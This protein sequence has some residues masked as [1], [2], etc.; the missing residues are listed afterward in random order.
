MINASKGIARILKME[1]TAF[2]SLF[3]TCRLN[4]AIGDEGEIPIIMMRDERYGVAVADAFSR[5]SDGKKF[6]VC[7]VQGGVNAAGLEFA[8]AAIMQAFEDSSPVLCLTDGLPAFDME[9]SH[10]QA[11]RVFSHITRWVSS[12]PNAQRVPDYMARAFTFLKT[13]RPGPVLLQVPPNLGDY[14]EEQYPYEPVK[15]WK[16]QADP[17][18]VKSVVRSLL[19]AK[20]PL[21]YVGEGVFRA[22]ACAELR[23]FVEVSQIP[24]LTTLKGKS[25]FPENH[26][27]SVGVRGEPGEYYLDKCDLLLALGSSLSPNRF[28]H[29]IP[30]AWSKT[31]I[32]CTID[33]LDINKSYRVKHALIGDSKLVL[34]QLTEDFVRHTSGGVRPK[35]EVLDE[36]KAART[37][38]VDKYGPLQTSNEKPINPYRVYYNLQKIL[39]PM[40]SFVT[41]E[42]G[43]PRDQLSTVFQTII[44]HGF[45]G[46]G[47]ISTLGFSLAGAIA[48][49]LVFPNR[50]VVNV[51]GDAGIGY[52]LGNLEAPLRYN[53]GITTIHIN[54]SGFAGYGPGFW[55]SGEHPYACAVTPSDKTNLAKAIESMGIY[56]ERVT[57]PS[58]IVPAI[59]RAMEENSSNRPAYLEFIC[60]QHPV[61][62]VWVGMKAKGTS[63]SQYSTGA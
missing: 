8:T 14:D 2:V 36:I 46:W 42:S 47:N 18:D 55:G 35:Q 22:D 57:E 1:G 32:Q 26:P 3:P 50:Q 27:L 6:G 11:D 31:I 4:N 5:L 21:L 38:L 63:R 52:M 51:T 34:Q 54:N 40:N 10:F 16:S 49:K 9:N 45:L 48:A 43:S 58:E 12:I 25:A 15:G 41:A 39:D 30:N 33:N 23:E 53:L 59:K 13:G 29:T 60:S 28:S 20:R 7:T 17:D 24:V 56:A 37:K 44:P 62:G 61:W 19:L